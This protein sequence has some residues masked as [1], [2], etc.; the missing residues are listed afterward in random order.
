MST[1][2][3]PRATVRRAAD[4]VLEHL[5]DVRERVRTGQLR[6]LAGVGALVLI[7]VVFRVI[8]PA[9]LTPDNLVA[10]TLQ[11][12]SLG[13]LALG[14]VLVMMIGQI[15]LSVGAVSGL[16]S[17]IVAVVFMQADLPLWVAVVA[18]VACG[19][20]IGLVYGT[21]SAYLGLPSFVLTLAGL[22]VVLGVQLWVLGDTGSINLP[23]DTWL[24]RFSQQGFLST[25]TSLL[26]A[27]GVVALNAWTLVHER[28]RRERADL[29]ADSLVWIGLKVV[30]LAVL[31]AVS[32][33]YLGKDRGIGYPVA[34]LLLVVTLTDVGLR[35]TRWG[36]AVRAVGGNVDSA[37]RAGMQVRRVT[38]QVFVVS[39]TFAAVG[40]VLAVG[41]LAAANQGSGG[42]EA[43]LT[44]IAAV[45]IGGVS[46]FGGRG[47]AWSAFVGVLV[48]QSIASG[49]T[50][51]N[52]GLS[53]RYMIIG[54]VLVLA[55]ALD[56]RLKRGALQ[57]R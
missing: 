5:A 12:A 23:F 30:G 3:K 38:V 42:A 39:S 51:M 25:T 21:L 10:L 20:A 43:S 53:V 8:S 50:L 17:A 6:S 54:A 15:D 16:S 28:G 57:P 49:L 52:A 40:G 35:R 19:A 56:T 13:F 11:S 48:V 46:L 29:P 44:A 26:V 47:S 24:V 14:V 18:A 22:L 31:L 4:Q 45:L 9:F 34:L 1:I 2:D 37:R 32:I 33:L 36:R 41:R 55:V 27:A 7:W